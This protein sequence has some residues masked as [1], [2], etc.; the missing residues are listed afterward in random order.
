VARWENKT[1]SKKK[2]P[3]GKRL[4]TDMERIPIP[5]NNVCLDRGELYDDR[6]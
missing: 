2:S 3:A 4:L 1:Q 6:I 5:V